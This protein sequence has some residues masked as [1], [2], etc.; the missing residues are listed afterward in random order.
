MAVVGNAF[1]MRVELEIVHREFAMALDEADGDGPLAQHALDADGDLRLV[2]ALDQHAA[3]VGFDDGSVVEP[4]PLLARECRLLV[5][6]DGED[7]E[8][9]IAPPHHRQDVAGALPDRI[10][11]AVEIRDAHL[12]GDLI[13]AR[14]AAADGV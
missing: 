6:I 3:S 14:I 13:D 12:P 8:Q 4:D 10:L 5:G 11:G 2:G 1:E 9:R 7:C